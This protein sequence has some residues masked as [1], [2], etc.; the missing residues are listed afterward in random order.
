MS[1]A[2]PNAMPNKTPPEGSSE[3]SEQRQT[4][5]ERRW[6]QT[7]LLNTEAVRER[8][9]ALKRLQHPGLLKIGSMEVA[10]DREESQLDAKIDYEATQL[11]VQR[12]HVPGMTLAAMRVVGHTLRLAQ[13]CFFLVRAGKA[14]LHLHRAGFQHGDIS[15]QNVV[16]FSG[17]ASHQRHSGQ[18]VFID[19]LQP[20]GT[21][22]GT[23]GFRAP[24]LRHGLASDVSDVY[25]LA[26]TALWIVDPDDHA[27]LRALLFPALKVEPNERMNLSELV[28]VFENE[29]QHPLPLFEDSTHAAARLRAL[30]LMEATSTVGNFDEPQLGSEPARLPRKRLGPRN[31]RPSKSRAKHRASTSVWNWLRPGTLATR[32]ERKRSTT[33]IK[34]RLTVT[35]GIF[36]LIWILIIAYG[37]QKNHPHLVAESGPPD[38]HLITSEQQYSQLAITLTHL[39]DMWINDGEDHVAQEAYAIQDSPVAVFDRDLIENATA[40]GD[41]HGQETFLEITNVEINQDADG[42]LVQAMVTSIPKVPATSNLGAPGASKSDLLGQSRCIILD[43]RY[44]DPS[45]SSPQ[46]SVSPAGLVEARGES[47]ASLSAVRTDAQNA[48]THQENHG[49]H[50]KVWDVYTC[51][52][53]AH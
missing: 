14:L 5:G 24:E 27:K 18:P 28:E 4:M 10:T 22:L 8:V 48:V 51:D 9:S 23:P 45:P 40:H 17:T 53:D 37:F 47:D 20:P 3:P 7:V 25:A 52:G 1:N 19:Y 13:V 31:R 39:R 11:I 34:K 26:A 21:H 38:G 33:Q 6:R 15:P 30:G 12:E 16:I 44:E 41:I 50:Y 2:M 32:S 36:G 35:I 29:E 49:L 42:A 43:L 46:D